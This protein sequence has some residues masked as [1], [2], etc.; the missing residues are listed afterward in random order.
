MSFQSVHFLLFLPLA[1]G[2][3]F[4]LPAR[5][6]RA[7]LL[8]ASYYYY[9]FA[10]PRH[11]VVLLAGTLFSYLAVRLI[12]AA[13]SVAA[14]RGWLAFGILGMVAGLCLFKYSG[15]IEPVFSHI[16][17]QLGVPFDEAAQ[18][19]Y[20]GYFS[21]A[22]ALG[23]S[24]Y[25]FAAVGYLIDV[26][27]KDV[28]VEKNFLT[29]A[30][31]LGFFPSVA[32]GPIP[33]AAGLM[34][35]LRD[36][37]RRFDPAG[38]AAGLRLMATGFFKKL[39]VSDTLAVFVNYVYA[40]VIAEKPE[41]SG[42]TLTLAAFLFMLQLYFDFSSYTD[43]AR[44]AAAIFGVA[45]PEN[46]NTPYYATNFSAFWARWHMSLSSWLQDYIFTPL[47]WSRWP[48][49]LPVIGKRVQNP[50][51]LSS[52]AAVFLIS[53]LWHGDTLCF[54]VWGALMA[55][56]RIGEELLHRTLGKPK[57]NPKPLARAGK[58]AVVLLLWMEGLVFFRVGIPASTGPGTVQQAASALLRQ[59][60]GISLTQTAAAIWQ[61]VSAIFF[62]KTYMIVLF[63]LFIVV[64]LLVALWADW[65]QCFR[66]GGVRPA[67][68]I[69]RLK[70]AARW[71]VYFF[72]VLACFAAFLAQNGGFGNVSFLYGGF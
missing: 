12:G 6:R 43:I 29:H 71:G 65:M 55:A 13:N 41:L 69:P 40:D 52:I 37:S 9:F 28:P 57:K 42:F 18:N 17:E 1:A 27:N 47:V 49:K 7:W 8:L 61:S 70:P 34:P 21:T 64:C 66:W 72:L 46:F 51:V 54:L 14:R 62:N 11:L 20:R 15:S 44:G 23:V 36:T 56:Y 25:T 31:F 35:Q 45:L 33:R 68:V 3:Y 67:E 48:E 50:P 39:A 2:A 26:Y 22:A 59:F 30:L 4:L 63:L 53:G 10:A 60:T 32:S 24:F 16:F 38:A 5:F 19:W 58:T